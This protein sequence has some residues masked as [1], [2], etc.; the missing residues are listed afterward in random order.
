ME[1]AAKR[2]EADQAIEKAFEYFERFFK[3]TPVTAV[4]LEGLAYE[5]VGDKWRVVI[6]FELR[7]RT[8]ETRELTLF[9]KTTVAPIREM[10]TF[11]ISARN[12]NMLSME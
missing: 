3:N 4:L 8:T 6:G 2:L 9:G 5:E 1:V 12:G 7:G 11:F 10:R